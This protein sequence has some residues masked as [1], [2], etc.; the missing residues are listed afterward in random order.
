MVQQN[1]GLA[2]PEISKI[3]GEQWRDESEERKNQWKLLAEEEKQRHQR[4]YPDYRYQPRR[5][6]KAGGAQSTRPAAAPG[7]DPHRCNKCGGRYIATPRT[8]STPFPTPTVS[9]PAHAP[10]GPP[11]LGQHPG[12]APRTDMSR[13]GR[14]HPQWGGG[15]QSTPP[16]LNDVHEDGHDDAMSPNEAK[17]RRYNAAGSYHNFHAL[18]SPPG[19]GASPHTPHPHYT[20][21][22][23]YYGHQAPFA[24]SN[25]PTPT[26][27]APP[28]LPGPYSMLPGPDHHQHHHQH[29]QPNP[30]P[31][32]PGGPGGPTM[33]PPPRPSRSVPVPTPVVTTTAHDHHHHYQHHQHT[34]TPH[35]RTGTFGVGGGGG[36]GGFGGGFGVGGVGGGVGGGGGGGGGGT[37]GNATTTTTTETFDESLRLPPLQTRLPV[38]V[39]GSGSAASS[40][41]PEQNNN[42]AGSSGSEGVGSG[43]GMGTGL[44]I[45]NPSVTAP[46]YRD[47]DGDGAAAGSK[48]VEAMV[49]GISFVNKL[50]VL[51]RISPPLGGGEQGRARGPVITVEGM[52][53]AAVA[54]VAGVVERALRAVGRGW[55]VGCW[56]AEGGE[57]R[58]RRESGGSGGGRGGGAYVNAFSAY[59]RTITEWHAKSAEI[60]RFVTNTAESS[61][62]TTTTTTTT[63]TSTPPTNTNTHPTHPRLYTSSSSSSNAEPSAEQPTPRHPL[64]HTT[65]TKN[66]NTRLPIALLPAGFSLTLADRFACAVP[67]A[68]AY[69]PVD[70]WQWMATL[71]R[72][73]VGADLVVYVTASAGSG[74]GG[75][76]MVEVRGAGLIVVGVPSSSGREDEVVGVDEKMER[77]LGFEVVEWVRAA[78]WMGGAAAGRGVEEVGEFRY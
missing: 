70:H 61:L 47:G 50:R 60:V 68:D 43:M 64:S 51:E 12:P 25:P 22:H 54:A 3:I 16:N 27:Y 52:D 42:T 37:G 65:A 19:P 58:G 77:R 24:T 62:T 59:L 57:R 1:P 31:R 46:G 11:P 7:E 23:P 49:M 69:A 17:R 53:A 45:I 20:Q 33:P 15:P 67:I 8:P 76:G 4:Q 40:S 38:P 35:P 18:P 26:M 75:V 13:H 73:I 56:E 41:S 39:G 72:G 48:G 14:Q 74:G 28:A 9:K 2:N 21:P 5:G 34:T 30:Y 10:Y 44:G 55:E 32:G 63:S 6:N 29:H 78:G 36:G 71:W 66:N